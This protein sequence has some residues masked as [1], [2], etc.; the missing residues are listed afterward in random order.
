MTDIV[1]LK[2]NGTPKYLKTH[3]DAIDGLDTKL[4]GLDSK[5]SN[6]IN[7][8]N[9]LNRGKQVW[10]GC[11]YLSDTQTITPS[12]TLDECPTGWLVLYQPY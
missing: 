4:D 1:Q 12:I 11:V 8:S 10:A 6:T 7:E 5:F 9:I 2:E 3:V